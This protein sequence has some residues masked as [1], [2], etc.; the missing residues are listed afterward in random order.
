MAI[1]WVIDHKGIP[2]THSVLI[3]QTCEVWLGVLSCILRA[4][5]L[6]NILSCQKERKG[7]MPVPGPTMII[8]VRGV[9]GM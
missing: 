5:F 3:K 6:A 8:G 4:S 9:S 2:L 7:A 1:D